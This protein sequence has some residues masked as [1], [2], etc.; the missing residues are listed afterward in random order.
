MHPS[1]VSYSVYAATLVS[2]NPLNILAG[3][4]LDSMQFATAQA[5]SYNRNNDISVTINPKLQLAI[6]GLPAINTVVLMK[7]NANSL[8]AKEWTLKTVR[9]EVGPTHCT[10][11]GRSVAWIDDTTVAVAILL[12][13]NRPWSQSEVWIFDVEKSFK[14][15]LFIFPNNQQNFILSISPMFL[16]IFIF[17]Q[18]LVIVTNGIY[19]LVVPSQPAGYV[20]TTNMT[21][22]GL[23]Y[24]MNSVKCNPGTF[25]N[26]SNFG[27]CTVCPPQTKN[28]GN[29]PCTSCELCNINSFCPLGSVD[30]VSLDK[31]PSYTQTFSYPSS[32]VMNNYDDLLVQN[33]FNIGHG[34]RC[35][36]ISP[37]F[38]T[39]I[40]IILCCITWFCM[41]LLQVYSSPKTHSHRAKAKELLKR[42]DIV[43]EG[44]R[45][46]GGL[47]S[48]AIAV[49]FGFTFWFSSDFLKLYPIETSDISY[50]SC[51]NT[52]RNAVFESSL[53]LALPNPNGN[54]RII[55]HMLD[56]QPFTMTMDL[57]NTIADCSSVT[58]QQNRPGVNNLLLPMTSCVRQPDNVT[59]SVSFLLPEHRTNVQ[60]N[61]TGSY[62][63]GGMRLCL[64]GPDSTD[65]VHTLQTLD[66]CQLFLTSNQTL[67]RTTTLH[68]ELIKVI[69]ETKP[70]EVGGNTYYN[71]RWALTFAE[72]SLSDKLIYE[73][74]GLY[75]RYMSERTV[76][77]ITLSEQPF[78]LQN[79]QQPIVR[80]PELAFHTLLFCTLI[81]ELFGMAFLL[82]RL[83]VLPLIRTVRQCYH[84][85]NTMETIVQPST[86]IAEPIVQNNFNT[87]EVSMRS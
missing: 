67:A 63:I 36:V 17:S 57:L 78:Y 28:T 41:A 53:Q 6:I 30:D 15:P 38:W 74:D 45:W 35:I 86:I 31:Y 29:Q 80:R 61:I 59:L 26:T 81:I 2:L 34:K 72:S 76:L 66:M 44:E 10:G 32:P 22:K 48:F 69:N 21:S 27:P 20:S 14:I 43:S 23:L 58:V 52:I 39:I 9:S 46:V 7:I 4:T 8:N 77:S 87:N 71:G 68:V 75:L 49:L 13:P 42:L 82:V 40:V 54:Q 18:S 55:F 85:N 3:T 11:F 64:R 73:Q 33:V 84:R 5:F 65:G 70:L 50:A 24:V 37:L 62:F 47:F 79:I 25:K 83:V 1:A 16:Q 19:V 12:V 51:D 60:L 56:S